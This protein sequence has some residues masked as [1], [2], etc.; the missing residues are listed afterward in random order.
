MISIVQ[1]S[2]RK[3]RVCIAKPGLTNRYIGW[4]HL[5]EIGRSE[6]LSPLLQFLQPPLGFAQRLIL[7]AE[8]EPHLLR[9]I[10]GIAVKAGAGHAGDAD[11]A[12][13]KF[14]EAHVIREAEARDIGHDVVGPVRAEASESA[15]FQDSQQDTAPPRIILRQV[16]II[17]R[18]Q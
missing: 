14:R 16:S 18:R 11:F 4:N 17:T 3:N 9:S 7:F 1:F 2:E 15:L 6:V 8:R 13:E 5:E 12:D 10:G